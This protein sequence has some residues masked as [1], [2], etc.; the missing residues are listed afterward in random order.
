M[1]FS[2][3]N[4]VLGVASISQLLDEM[5]SPGSKRTEEKRPR[6]EPSDTHKI[7][8]SSTREACKGR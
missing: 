6:T 5:R 1:E 8:G 3:E 7:Q 2:E 4:S